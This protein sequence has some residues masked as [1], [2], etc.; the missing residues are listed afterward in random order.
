MY[1]VLLKTKY[2]QKEHKNFRVRA[3]S[4]LG[5]NKT[6]RT[7]K[8]E[9]IYVDNEPNPLRDPFDALLQKLS[10]GYHSILKP[11]DAT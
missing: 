10:Q 5:K 4:Y 11:E 8:L 3:D 9:V 6:E 2:Q 7:Y 1:R